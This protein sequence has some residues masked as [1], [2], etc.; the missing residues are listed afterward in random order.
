MTG[1]APFSAGQRA[2]QTL[3]RRCSIRCYTAPARFAQT[4]CPFVIRRRAPQLSQ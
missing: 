1:G 4:F 3:A 2:M